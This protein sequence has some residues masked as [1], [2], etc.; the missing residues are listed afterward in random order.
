VQQQKNYACLSTRITFRTAFT[1]SSIAMTLLV[2][3]NGIRP[4]KVECWC[5][6]LV[7]IVI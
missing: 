2:G 1:K 4:C 5:R 7:I 3:R 6:L